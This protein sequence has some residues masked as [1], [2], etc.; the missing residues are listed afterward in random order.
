MVSAVFMPLLV[1]LI[2]MICPVLFHGASAGL[3]PAVRPGLG[4]Q[5]GRAPKVRHE[6]ALS[7]SQIKPPALPEV[8]DFTILRLFDWPIINFPERRFGGVKVVCATMISVALTT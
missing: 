6:A 8:T 5:K 3:G 4:D 1:I 2:E 7:G